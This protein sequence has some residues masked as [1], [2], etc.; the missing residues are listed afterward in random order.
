MKKGKI[1]IIDDN[2]QILDSLKILLKPEFE[3]IHAISN[4][5]SIPNKLRSG[6]F[7]IILLD[8]NFASGRTSGNEGIFWLREILKLDPHIVVILITAYGDIELA[9][10]SIKE[11]AFDFITKPWDAEK[12]IITLKNA[13]KLRQ[14]KH[15]INKLKLKKDE[16][17]SEIEKHYQLFIGQSKAFKDVIF[18]LEKVADTDANVLILGENGT[19]KEII[20]REI[21]R[22]S[23]RA[24]D[25]FINVDVASISENLFESEMFGHVKGSFTDAKEDRIGKIEA[26]SGGTLFLDEIGN[27]PLFLQSKLLVVLQN[28]QVVRVGSNKPVEVDIRLICATNK[29]VY[30]MVKEKTFREDLLYRINTIQ[31]E[32]PPLRERVDDIPGFANYFLIQYACKYN[33]Q[34]LKISD[35]AYEK[36]MKY[37]WPGNIRELKHAIEK[38]VILSDNNKI[39]AD[40]FLFQSIIS[41]KN[42]PSSLKLEEVEKWAIE[43]VLH[44]CNGN[45]SKAA[46][47][48]EVSRTTL[49][50]KIEKYKIFI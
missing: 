15:E 45:L 33:K 6:S 9:V 11:G 41:D 35:K 30:D 18:T 4:P 27:L 1:L 49:Y 42:T 37:S 10:N 13:Y 20:A 7:D 16:L 29:P 22:R 19:G 24:R 48:L 8:M 3:E 43:S 28:R 40:D 50:V 44:K 36:L 31:I 39:D 23:K 38:V 46:K 12:L 5:N 32:I 47:V 21:H 26:S 2:K 25:I 17:S 14:S 34:S